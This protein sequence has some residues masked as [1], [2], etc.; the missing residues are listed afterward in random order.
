[1]CGKGKMAAGSKGWLSER[2]EC[3]VCSGDIGVLT[4]T[5]KD[6]VGNCLIINFLMRFFGNLCAWSQLEML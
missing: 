3:G 4:C 5:V 6:G 1:M 2:V